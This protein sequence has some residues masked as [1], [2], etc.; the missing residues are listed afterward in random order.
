L[1][2]KYA[3]GVGIPRDQQLAL[4]WFRKAADQGIAEAQYNLGLAYFKGDGIAADGERA[5]YWWTLSA[6]RGYQGA[7]KYREIAEKMLTEEQ[8]TRVQADANHWKPVRN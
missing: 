2:V 3:T 5:Y 4:S 8:R 7:I 1:G 6:N